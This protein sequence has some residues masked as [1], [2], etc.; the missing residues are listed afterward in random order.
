MGHMV[1]SHLL[2]SSTHPHAAQ[3]LQI[4]SKCQS[5]KNADQHGTDELHQINENDNIGKHD[6][7]FN[8]GVCIC[9][10]LKFQFFPIV[11]K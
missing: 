6:I 5:C 8:S 9:V 7:T 10:I 2:L 4:L 11:C 3:S 1:H